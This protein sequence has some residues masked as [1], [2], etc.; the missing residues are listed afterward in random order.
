GPAPTGRLVPK[1]LGNLL[2]VCVKFRHAV[3]THLPGPKRIIGQCRV[4]QDL[5]IHPVVNICAQMLSELTRDLFW[6]DVR[7]PRAGPNAQR[8][9]RSVWFVADG[10]ERG[11]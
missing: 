8:G 11:L 6:D 1:L 3:R 9:P 5:S 2:L 7:R 10:S 4:A